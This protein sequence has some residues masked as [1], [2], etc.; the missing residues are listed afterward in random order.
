MHKKDFIH[1]KQFVSFDPKKKVKMESE[2]KSAS[3]AGQTAMCWVFC[4]KQEKCANRMFLKSCSNDGQR[5]SQQFQ[6]SSNIDRIATYRLKESMAKC[7]FTLCNT[8]QLPKEMIHWEGRRKRRPQTQIKRERERGRER[9]RE[10]E[11]KNTNLDLRSDVDDLLL[12]NFGLSWFCRGGGGT[13]M[14][15][16]HGSCSRFRSSCRL[17]S[18]FSG[19]L[20][21]GFRGNFCSCFTRWYHCRFCGS[22][23]AFLLQTWKLVVGSI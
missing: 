21:T 9:E 20:Q 16:R 4:G 22:P 15:D 23:F 3:S 19:F 1:R 10:R 2:R 13:A 12:R 11:T 14:S 17:P 18:C 6:M 7:S 8:T 5:F